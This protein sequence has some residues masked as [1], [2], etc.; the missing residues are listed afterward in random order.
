MKTDTIIG[1]CI[2]KG[3]RRPSRGQSRGAAQGQGSFC[4]HLSEWPAP[5]LSQFSETKHLKT[6]TFLNQSSGAIQQLQEPL[7]LR[8]SEASRRTQVHLRSIHLAKKFP[9]S[10][11]VPP[12]CLL[13]RKKT[14]DRS[15]SL[16]Q[17][18]FFGGGPHSPAPS[19]LPQ[20][21]YLHCD[22]GAQGCIKQ[23]VGSCPMNAGKAPLGTSNYRTRTSY[24][25][26]Y[27][28]GKSCFPEHGI[29]ADQHRWQCER[30]RNSSS[31]DRS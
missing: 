7:A 28:P 11:T 5:F 12:L 1:K 17:A 10:T 14:L 23:E 29:P 8:T 6:R 22:G 25:T 27:T 13:N 30:P 4:S 3:L 20:V 21:L 26:C 9:R 24:V 18:P 15:S 16:G 2:K 19:T 31:R